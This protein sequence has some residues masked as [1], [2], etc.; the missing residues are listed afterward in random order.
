M[1]VAEALASCNRLLA[2]GA[3]TEARA[4]SVAVY[5][6]GAALRSGQ[7]SVKT[8][9]STAIDGLF[10]HLDLVSCAISAPLMVPLAWSS[11]DNHNDDS[12]IKGSSAT[13]HAYE[14]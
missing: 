6:H 8:I 3:Y 9:N 13:L 12:I 10:T 4:G 5:G 7:V 14:R 1:V 11:D 2:T